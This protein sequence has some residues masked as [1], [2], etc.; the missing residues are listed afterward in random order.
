MKKQKRGANFEKIKQF[1]MDGREVTASQI[2]KQTGVKGNIY[3]TLQTMQKRGE[4]MKIG[5]LYRISP[6]SEKK[7]P[8]AVDKTDSLIFNKHI[9][10]LQKELDHIKTGI[11]QLRITANYISLRIAEEKRNALSYGK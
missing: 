1:L 6:L 2:Q 9:I 7:L 8:I 3:S 5:M 10:A 4:V 11:E